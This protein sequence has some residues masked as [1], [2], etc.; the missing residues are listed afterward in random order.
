MEPGGTG[1]IVALIALIGCSAFFSSAETAY[2]SANH[3]R[4]KALQKAGVK[5]ADLALRLTD[6][7]DRLLTTILIGNNIV[8][9]LASSL[10]TVVFIHYVGYAGVTVSTI[11]MTLLVL[12]FGEISPKTLAKDRAERLCIAFAPALRL[13]T[14]LFTPINWVFSQW[15]RLLS[16]LF[17]KPVDRGLA[18]EELLTIVEE[19]VEDGELDRRESDLIRSA[20]EFDDLCAEDILTHR[21]DIVALYI[22]ATRAEAEAVF[23][24]HSF[25]RL[26]VYDESIDDIVGIVHEK[27]FFNNRNARS[28]RALMHTPLFVTPGAKLDDL[29]KMLQKNKTHMAIVS[30]EYGGTM[31]LITMEDIL[32]QLVGEIYDEHDEVTESL[33]RLSDGS[34]LCEGAADLD[35]LREAVPFP[36]DSDAATV[37]GWVMERMERIPAV[38]DRF[39]EDGWTITVTDADTTRVLE[40]ALKKSDEASEDD[41]KT[42]NKEDTRS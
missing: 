28:L 8:N 27:D 6:E 23:R 40:I 39:T 19:A 22:G 35:T 5:H 17:P 2:N 37:G 33:R 18:E 11:V 42:N 15:R 4:L 30:D 20:I 31:G 12:I 34:L 41:K 9:I 3:A 13:L 32:E 29:L 38:G 14:R 36:V 1:V 10:A 25:S 21:V 26:P 16:R 24:E 7:Y